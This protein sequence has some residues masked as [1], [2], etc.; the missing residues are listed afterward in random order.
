MLLLVGCGNYVLANCEANEYMNG[1]ETVITVIIIM[2]HNTTNSAFS[3]LSHTRKH[4]QMHILVH[5]HKLFPPPQQLYIKGTQPEKPY[6]IAFE[7]L[8]SFSLSLQYSLCLHSYLAPH[9][10]STIKAEKGRR[11][12]VDR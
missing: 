8:I 12:E 9:W 3:L 1:C 10:P 11:L 7:H 6:C 4:S 2:L 5:K